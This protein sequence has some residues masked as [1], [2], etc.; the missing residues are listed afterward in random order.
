[1]AMHQRLRPQNQPKKTLGQNIDQQILQ[2]VGG[3]FD[4]KTVRTKLL[5]IAILCDGAIGACYLSKDINAQWSPSISHPSVGRIPNR[6][7]F[8]TAMSENCEQYVK[9][10]SVNSQSLPSLKGAFGLFMTISPRN[11]S[12]ELMLLVFSS[13]NKS[14]GGMNTVPKL[15]TAIQLW[16][17]GRDSADSDWQVSALAAIIE[18]V[19]KIEN[20][21]T[22]KSAS[23]EAVNLLANRT[24]CSSVAIGLLRKNRMHLEAISGVTKIDKGSDSSRNYLQTLVESVTR[25]K[26]AVF[27]AKDE[28][29]NFLLQAHRQLGASVQS[30]AVY[31]QPLVLEDGTLF[32]A[33]AFTGSRALLNS[34]QIERFNDAAAPSIANALRIVEKVKPTTIKRTKA[35]IK[36]KISIGKQVAIVGAAILFCL[37]MFFPITYR[38]RCN[39][40]TEPVSRRFAVAPFDGQIVTG[41]AEAGDFVSQGEILAEMDGRTIRWELASVTAQR[42]QSSRTRGVV[43]SG[44]LERAE[45]ASIETGQVLFEVGPLKPMRVEIAVPGDEIAQVKAGFP[46]KVWIDGQEDEPIKGEIKKIHPRSEIRDAQNVFIAEIEFPNEDERLRP[47][48]KGSVRIDGEKRSLGWSLFHKPMNYVRSRLTWW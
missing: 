41:H 29:N 5:Q 35:Y 16:L 4:E 22:L 26:P 31:S 38:V 8:A 47:G 21:P 24:G 11:S 17:N 20:Q 48:M 19:A 30:E 28:E 42:E 12:P 18:L 37:L 43:L 15:A 23:E 13:Q 46:V 1:M 25:N 45:A 9:S 10:R 36:R 32:G 6:R 7:E 44:S 40:V 2:A 3:N 34:A 14:I 27:P 33:L 39:C